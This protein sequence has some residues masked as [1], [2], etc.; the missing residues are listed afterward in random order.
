MGLTRAS[1]N[2]RFKSERTWVILAAVAV[3]IIVLTTLQWDVNGSQSPYAT[4]V[5]E[6]QN[7]LPR[8]GTLHFTGY[9]LYTF[10]GSMWVSFL[11]LLGVAPA[12][13]AS[14]FSAMWG[15]AAAALLVLLAV[16]LGV[17]APT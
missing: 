11:R 15:A 3:L 2:V 17:P 1:F 4:D 13:G 6:I 8:W 5:G 7:A 12:A 14:L 9:P 10:V 16:E